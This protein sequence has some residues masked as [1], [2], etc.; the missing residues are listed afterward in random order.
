M[1]NVNVDS[2]GVTQPL[3]QMYKTEDTSGGGGGGVGVPMGLG[4]ARTT[5][6]RHTAGGSSHTH[7]QNTVGSALDDDNGGIDTGYKEPGPE[8][9]C[10]HWIGDFAS[11]YTVCM[12][13]PRRSDEGDKKGGLLGL[14]V[15]Q[16]VTTG[17][18]DLLGHK[19][20]DAADSEQQVLPHCV[21]SSCHSPRMHTS[22]IPPHD[23]T[24]LLS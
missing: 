2:H 4:S 15:L 7:A 20:D 5:P 21:Q 18:G 17:I 10:T 19:R 9:A 3:L 11:Q 23:W 22:H 1:K 16:H 13:L 24:G 8:D 14:G 12:V 6:L